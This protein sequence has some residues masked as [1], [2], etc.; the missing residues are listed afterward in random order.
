MSLLLSLCWR[1]RFIDVY[2]LF[3]FVPVNTADAAAAA[4]A[5]DDDNDGDGDDDVYR[6]RPMSWDDRMW[7]SCESTW[8]SFD[9]NLL[10]NFLFSRCLR[11]DFTARFSPFYV[12]C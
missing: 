2:T 3:H 11:H 4:A 8:I 10:M 7:R 9:R 5:D 12:V 1:R 6:N